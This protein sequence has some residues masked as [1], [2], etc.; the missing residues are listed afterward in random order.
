L[1]EKPARVD[2][3]GEEFRTL[4]RYLKTCSK[5]LRNYILILVELVEQRIEGW[6]KV[7]WC[8]ALG[9]LPSIS[10]S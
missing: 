5:S 3:D 9:C 2:A 7:V 6:Q 10:K 4:S 1:E 8:I